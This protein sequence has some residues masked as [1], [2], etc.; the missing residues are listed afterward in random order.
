MCEAYEVENRRLAQFVKDMAL[1]EKQEKDE[2]EAQR[3]RLNAERMTLEDGQH[4]SP[5]S[6]LIC[7]APLSSLFLLHYKISCGCLL[8]CLHAP[9]FLTHI[10]LHGAPL[11]TGH[12]KLAE[13]VASAA[14]V[15]EAK[16]SLEGQVARLETEK[17]D[18]M[19]DYET[20][21][22]K[23]SIEKRALGEAMQQAQVEVRCHFCLA[24]RLQH[25]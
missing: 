2:M 18:Q 16:A 6:V 11:A 23:L 20:K 8:C 5:S 9:N 10:I 14:A 17:H 4:C 19:Q 13:R 21:L 24:L 25:I 1:R 22:T 7:P 12:G 3:N 15:H